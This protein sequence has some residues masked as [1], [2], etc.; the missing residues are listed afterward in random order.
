MV[1]LSFNA[2]EVE[3]TSGFDLIPKGD[4]PAMIT[5]S[6]QK[7]TNAGDGTYIALTFQICQGKHQNRRLWLNLNLENKNP[8]AVKIAS[9]QLSAICRAVGVMSPKDTS[10]LHDKPMLI[11][12]GHR[13]NK[14]TGELENVI[15]NFK[16]IAAGPKPQPQPTQNQ[17]QPA[18]A[19]VTAS[20][21]G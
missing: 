3:P 6:E 13:K 18:T 8:E 21:W 5:S 12:I 15:N 11:S 20:P 19:G 10:E 14:Q 9:G 7:T 17:G 4:E 2:N 1:A 16:P